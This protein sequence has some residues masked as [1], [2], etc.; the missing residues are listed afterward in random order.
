MTS[1]FPEPPRRPAVT[2]S[3]QVHRFL[4]RLGEVLDEVST[5][6]VWAL[7]Q[8]ELAESLREAYAA[9][10][11][12]QALTLRLVAQADLNDL[13]SHEG[14]VSLPAWL[15]VQVRLA[16]G[17]AKRQVRLAKALEAHQVTREAL[18]AGGFPAASAAVITEAVDALPDEIDPGLRVQA[19]EFLAGEAHLH[20]TAALRRLAAHVEEVIDPDGAEERLAEQL[21]RAEEKA[22]RQACFTLGH[23]QTTASS[24]GRFKLPLLSGIKLERML[25]ALLNPNRPDPIGFEDP[26]TGRPYTLEERR[27]QA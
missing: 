11:R 12:L 6:T 14:A 5:D 18:T 27:G 25:Q 23:D 19:E 15:R 22:A 10:A 8:Q 13:A 24:Q 21:A 4:G 17:E 3:H 2:R 16:P 7:S 9:Q 1:P 26:E 20:D